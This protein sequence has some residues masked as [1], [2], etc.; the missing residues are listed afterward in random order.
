MN[1]TNNVFKRIIGFQKAPGAKTKE[2]LLI[3]EMLK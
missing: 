1:T 3:E 2:E